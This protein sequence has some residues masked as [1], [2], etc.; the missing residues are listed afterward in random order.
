M[1]ELRLLVLKIFS[2]DNTFALFCKSLTGQWGGYSPPLATL[3]NQDNY[4]LVWIGR[5]QIDP[6]YFL[7][8]ITYYR[9]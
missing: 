1:S 3:L 6:G 7:F 5:P 4:G 2:K 9:S 8:I